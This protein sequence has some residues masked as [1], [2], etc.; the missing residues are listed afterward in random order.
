MKESQYLLD[1]NDD[2]QTIALKDKFRKYLAYWPWFLIGLLICFLIGFLYVRYASITYQS[3][4]KVKIIDESKELD[5]ATD[6]L[7]LLEGSSKINME[8]EIEVLTSYRILS[9]VVEELNLDIEYSEVGSI[10]ETET[11]VAPITI[12]KIKT[13]KPLENSRTLFVEMGEGAFKVFDE[14]DNPLTLQPQDDGFKIANMPLLIRP[15]DTIGN[16]E[17]LSDRFEIIVLPE[18][19]AV[20]E[21]YD[22]LE[23]QAT[24]EK[25]EILSISITGESVEKNEAILN[26]LIKKFDQDGILDRQLVNKRTVDFIDDRFVYLSGEL[27]SIEGNKEEFK[28]SNNL[29]NMAADTE[30]TLQ[31]K[32][33]AEQEVFNIQTQIS[34]ANLLKETLVNEADFGL[35]PAN[36]GLENNSINSLVSEYNKSVLERER[37]IASAGSN[38]PTLQVLSEQLQRTK[39]NIIQTVN[40]YVRQLRVT[41]GQLNQQRAQAGSMFSSL[42]QKEKMLRAI[43]RQQSIKENLFILLLQKREEAAINLAVTAPTIKVVDYGLTDSDPVSPNEK[44]IYGISLLGGLLIPFL[45]L[46]V[47]FNLDTK[48]RERKEL[49]RVAPRVPILAEI[50]YF[51]NEKVFKQ[52][53]DH[54]LLAE[55]FR[56]LSTNVDFLL[57]K[58]KQGGGKVVFVTSTIKEEGK[59]MIA[60][61]ISLA[62]ASIKKKVLLIG[63]DLRNPKLHN[64]FGLDKNVTGLSNYLYDPSMNWKDCIRNGYENDP[65]H[66]VCLSGVIPPNAPKLLSNG[67]FEDFINQA[68]KEYDYIIV[69]T[70]P[71]ILVTDTFLISHLADVTL[72]VVRAG[73]TDKRLLDFSKDLEDKKKLWNMAYVLNDVGSGVATNYNYGY[74]YGYH[75]SSVKKPWYKRIVSSK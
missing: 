68:K 28:E 40:V 47:R 44:I 75:E 60:L 31:K 25:S 56:I 4:A 9:Q 32:S 10:K 64:F 23:V 22:K 13:E 62:Y 49:E 66:N 34:L 54:S 27:D 24:S 51:E 11:W 67:S 53:D 18:K 41:L 48:V 45:I 39:Q 17:W 73:L 63:S 3:V 20:L 1:I 7:A 19:E 12:S 52:A 33:V 55:S 59:T 69:D 61:N 16:T 70:A 74:S 35:L 8:N 21:L 58:E 50:P 29:S 37:L 72:Y 46:F 71:T 15:N 2:D 5:I 36:I 26:T 38:N 30:M 6:P 14:D 65:Y 43:E 42:P 57:P